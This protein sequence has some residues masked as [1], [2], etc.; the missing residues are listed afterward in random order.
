MHFVT[1]LKKRAAGTAATGQELPGVSVSDTGQT[2]RR[3]E[4]EHKRIDKNSRAAGLRD[5]G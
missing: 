4:D 2:N 3:Q 1:P 5:H